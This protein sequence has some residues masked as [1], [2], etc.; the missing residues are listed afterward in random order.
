MTLSEATVFDAPDAFSEN[1]ARRLS[2][3][4]VRKE[5]FNVTVVR[6]VAILAHG[7]GS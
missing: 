3:V 4:R 6:E 2:S 7:G 5:I 1:P